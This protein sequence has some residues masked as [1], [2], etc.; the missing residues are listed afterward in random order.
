MEEENM[1]F[2]QQAI[3]DE[4]RSEQAMEDKQ[5]QYIASRELYATVFEEKY[6]LAN[7]VNELRVI[8]GEE[9]DSNPMIKLLPELQLEKERLIRKIRA[10]E[11]RELGVTG[12]KA[13]AALSETVLDGKHSLPFIGSPNAKG[14]HEDQESALKLT[15]YR[16]A[17]SGTEESWLGSL[18]PGARLSLNFLMSL[19]N[20]CATNRRIPI[21]KKATSTTSASSRW[22]E[23]KNAGQV[24]VTTLVNRVEDG[25]D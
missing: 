11:A 1:K 21:H 3:E 15:A 22:K 12:L 7:E 8:V 19:I 14:F 10:A 18:P 23:S 24:D 16:N 20:R 5:R 17:F 6:R 4:K 13:L 2:Q 9:P 25:S